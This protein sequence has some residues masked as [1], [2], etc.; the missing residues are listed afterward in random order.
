MVSAS[1]MQDQLNEIANGSNAV[2]L[3]R[4]TIF[5]KH[6]VARFGVA[7][8]F[9]KCGPRQLAMFQKI[10]KCKRPIRCVVLIDLRQ[11]LGISRKAKV[12]KSCDFFVTAIA[13]ETNVFD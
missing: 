10:I 8:N 5:W 9:P 12:P 1:V 11:F 7:L 6:V 13:E 4:I 3:K 2:Q